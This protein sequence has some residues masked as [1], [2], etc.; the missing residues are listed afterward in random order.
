MPVKYIIEGDMNF[1]DELYKSLDDDTSNKHENNIMDIS[2]DKYNLCLITNSPLTKNF[3]TLDCKHKFNYMALYHDILN[4]KKKYNNMERKM[5][6]VTEL[7]CPY[8]R[9]VQSSLLPYYEN[10]NVKKVH[11]VNFFDE[12]Y[13]KKNQLY[14]EED[15]S[16]YIVGVCSNISVSQYGHMHSCQ[17]TQVTLLEE[18]NKHYCKHHKYY[19]IKEIAKNKKNKE[20]LELKKVMAEAK[21]KLIE[22]KAVE[23]ENAKLAKLAIKIAKAEDAK[24]IKT[25]KINKQQNNTNIII[26]SNNLNEQLVCTQILK[27]GA[28]KGEKCGCKLFQDNLCTRHYN[29]NN[30]VYTK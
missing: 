29:L 20:T 26:D 23:K 9:H 25:N 12:N 2:D 1:Y 27:T 7:R 4:H 6:K 3:V 22:L 21:Q 13:A 5:L 16:V 19:G 14:N 15:A 30:K 11:G 8:C 17:N 18:L 10:M 24:T 28:N